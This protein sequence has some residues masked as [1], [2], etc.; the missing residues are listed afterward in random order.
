MLLRH[1]EAFELWL[2]LLVSANDYE[3]FL[4]ADF[5]NF[6]NLLKKKIIKV[7][8]WDIVAYW[9]IATFFSDYIFCK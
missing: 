7:K 1:P 6:C 9:L 4:A 5:P 3:A 8:E 2:W